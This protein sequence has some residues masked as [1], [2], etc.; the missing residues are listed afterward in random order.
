VE[1]RVATES[2]TGVRVEQLD[3]SKQ[4]EQGFLRE[5]LDARLAAATGLRET[6]RVVL[7]VREMGGYEL[8]PRGPDPPLLK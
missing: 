3:R 7:R 5:I 8:A 1:S 2:V 4:P 6:A